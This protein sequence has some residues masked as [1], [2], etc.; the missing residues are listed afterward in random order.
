VEQV[1]PAQEA[2]SR[3][4]T[5]HQ[6]YDQQIPPGYPGHAPVGGAATP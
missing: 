1:E 2:D 5:P 6:P 4:Q 3:Q